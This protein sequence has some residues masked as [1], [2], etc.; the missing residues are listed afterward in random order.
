MKTLNSHRSIQSKVRS[1]E[2]GSSS[3]SDYDRLNARETGILGKT[4]FTT[5]FSGATARSGDMKSRG[6]AKHSGTN[7]G[8]RMFAN[9]SSL[10][11]LHKKQLS[12]N[13]SNELSNIVIE[14]ESDKIRSSRCRYKQNTSL[15]YP[16]KYQSDRLLPRKHHQTNSFDHDLSLLSGYS[17][18]DNVPSN[19][20]R[21]N[22]QEEQQILNIS[23]S[24][25][26]SQSDG[27]SENASMAKSKKKRLNKNLTKIRKKLK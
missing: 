12:A 6:H 17:M 7:S 3:D 4:R 14:Q 20:R 27:A 25:S 13:K 23:N 15:K 24:M 22:I 8:S 10:L 5:G 9:D 21:A 18:T 19:S 16:Q 26:S 1:R 2:G 11:N